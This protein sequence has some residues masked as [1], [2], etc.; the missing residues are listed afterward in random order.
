MNQRVHDRQFR[1]DGGK[2]DVYKS[3]ME[4]PETNAGSYK[5]GDGSG[6]NWSPIKLVRFLLLV[7]GFRV[8]GVEIGEG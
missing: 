3:E 6:V 1:I 8:R 7:D 4:D 2:Q 5:P